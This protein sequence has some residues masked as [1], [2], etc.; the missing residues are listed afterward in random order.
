MNEWM[1]F[2]DASVDGFGNCDSVLRDDKVE[3]LH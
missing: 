1:L 2:Y 3:W